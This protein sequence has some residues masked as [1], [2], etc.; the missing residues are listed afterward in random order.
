VGRSEVAAVWQGERQ[1]FNT[2]VSYGAS[3]MSIDSEP[4]LL[5]SVGAQWRLGS[6]A[7][8][9]VNAAHEIR[10]ESDGEKTSADMRV[11]WALRNR[12]QI[13][14]TARI[15]KS[16]DPAEAAASLYVSYSIPLGVPV[17]RKRGMGTIHGSVVDRDGETP[18]P[19]AKAVVRLNSGATTTTDREGRFTFAGLPPGDYSVTVDQRSLGF[20]RVSAERIPGEIF[21][22]GDSVTT[23][24]IAVV[25]AATLTVQ[26]TVF[27]E[28]LA[29]VGEPVPQS[30]P[31]DRFR[32][33]GALAGEVVELSNG[34]ETYRRLTGADGVVSF[35]NLRPGRWTMLA[36][37]RALPPYHQIEQ[38]RRELEL[39]PQ[40]KVVEVVRVL[41]R[42]RALQLIDTGTLN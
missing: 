40:A 36:Y 9:T 41:P 34:S 7:A 8:V 28:S 29:P 42:R 13:A 37:D 30:N 24:D 12:H 6:Q 33:V 5:A 26:I 39:R 38:P 19:I 17:A 22:K 31:E 16:N 15:A 14:A 27:T 35:T 11:D 3:A 23:I 32:P 10:P 21:V 18:Q 25:T 20:G 1:T 4:Q 2:F